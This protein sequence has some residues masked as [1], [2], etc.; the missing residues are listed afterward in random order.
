MMQ[1]GRQVSAKRFCSSLRQA[2]NDV[3][4]MDEYNSDEFDCH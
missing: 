1:F 2:I 3:A 4:I